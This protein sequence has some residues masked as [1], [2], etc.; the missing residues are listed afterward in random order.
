MG[1]ATLRRSSC[2]VGLTV[3]VKGSELGT[4]TQPLTSVWATGLCQTP[5]GF[6]DPDGWSVTCQG[7]TEELA[8]LCD[9]YFLFSCLSI[10][11]VLRHYSNGMICV[12]YC[13]I[14]M[15]LWYCLWML[16][17]KSY[18]S[19]LLLILALSTGV[20]SVSIAALTLVTECSMD[21]HLAHSLVWYVVQPSSVSIKSQSL[22]TRR[23]NS[24]SLLLTRNLFVQ[25][26]F[27]RKF[28]LS[29]S[30]HASPEAIDNVVFYCRDFY[31][32][33]TMS[34]FSQE[35]WGW[36][37]TKWEKNYTHRLVKIW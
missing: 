29:W 22:L 35:T 30:T 13:K 25:N 6:M 34:H 19:W 32:Q 17:N 31:V 4:V 21:T 36:K 16:D 27:I 3:L 37:R 11:F 5:R 2:L 23:P 33:K 20:S 24:C 18:H 26:N 15:H 14:E 28:Q 9:V 7:W 10:V 12:K 1:H 8:P